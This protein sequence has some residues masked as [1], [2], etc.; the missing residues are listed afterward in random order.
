MTELCAH[1]GKL[2]RLGLVLVIVGFAIPWLRSEDITLKDG[3]ILND[4]RVVSE[5]PLAVVIVYHGNLSSVSKSLLPDALAARYPAD[6]KALAKIAEEAKEKEASRSRTLAAAENG[7]PGAQFE[8]GNMYFTGDGEARDFA[9][10]TKW[11]RQAADQ[12]ENRAQYK[13]GRMYETGEGIGANSQE[14]A[15]WY[16][17]AAEQGNASAQAHLGLLYKKGAGVPKDINEAG[18]WIRKAAEQGD[19]PSQRELVNCYLTGEGMPLDQ[20]EALAW[21]HVAAASGDE[22]AKQMRNRIDFSGWVR[23]DIVLVVQHRSSELIQ[24]IAANKLQKSN[25]IPKSSIAPPEAATAKGNGSGTIVTTS[26]Y[27]LTAAHVVSGSTSVTVVTKQGSRKAKVIKVD[28]ANDVAVLKIDEGTYPALP[29]V[30]SRQAKMGQPVATIGF[31]NVNIQGFSPKVTR[32]EISSLNGP[33][34]DPR[35]WQISVPVQ[36]GNS[37]G[38]LLDENGNVIGIVV[39]RLVGGMA[40][41]VNYAV[42][43]SYALGLLDA[44][45]DSGSPSATQANPPPRFEDM[46]AKAEQSVVLVLVY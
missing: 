11:Y 32:G 36:P 22:E 15:N 37:G 18:L 5:S 46:V 24:A 12:G 30:S 19:V 28:E 42:K 41:N 23:G 9:K 29:V 38:P 10:A 2:P 39:A 4:A 7:D 43:S 1:L 16:R 14:A 35:K 45:L 33:G 34:D 21:L 44:Y 40:Q 20:L 13:L 3:R 8:A 31:P 27:I 25:P 26:G 17:K 6:Q